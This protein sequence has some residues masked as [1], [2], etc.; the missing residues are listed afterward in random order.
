VRRDNGR[1]IVDEAGLA[2]ERRPVTL[3]VLA[4]LLALE[5]LALWVTAVWELVALLTQPAASEASAIALLVLILIA[6]TWVSAIAVNVLRHRG[7]VR[8]A[9]VTWQIVQAAV[10]V[11]LLQGIGANVAVGLALI[12]PAVIVVALV[13]TPAVLAA[14]GAKEAGTRTS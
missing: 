7:W 2:S 5:A 12:I 6:A 13:F 4:G 11:G 9:A 3:L 14:T 1:N 10:G 8:G